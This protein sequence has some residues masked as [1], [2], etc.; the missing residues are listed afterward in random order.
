MWLLDRLLANRPVYNVPAVVRLVGPLDIVALQRALHEVVRRHE[1]LRTRFEV[2]DAM[3]VQV[4]AAEF[5]FGLE[6][7]DLTALVPPER[8]AAAQ[9][10]ARGWTGEN[11]VDRLGGS[12]CAPRR[13]SI[14][15]P[16]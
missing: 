2:E 6:V 3:P 16:E 13:E 7:E 4:I 5:E 1:T 8:E 15:G 12:S 14:R 11:F 9:R 10:P